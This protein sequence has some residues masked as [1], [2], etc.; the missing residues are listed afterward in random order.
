M[1]SDFARVALLINGRQI[2]TQ[3]QRRI[4]ESEKIVNRHAK[5]VLSILRF[6]PS[7]IINSIVINFVN[8]IKII[9]NHI[10]N[11]FMRHYA[12]MISLILLGIEDPFHSSFQKIVF[13]N[14]DLDFEQFADS[15]HI[16]YYFTNFDNN[17]LMQ[18]AMIYRH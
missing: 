15:I 17:I 8:V 3:K 2:S 10:H 5:T 6:N 13:L 11:A 14:I 1:N 7:L 18:S 12:R 4:V 9:E 16:S